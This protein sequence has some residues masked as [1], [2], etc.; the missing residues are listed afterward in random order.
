MGVI[1][2]PIMKKMLLQYKFDHKKF[3]L[4]MR[5]V[6]S[7][8]AIF[9]V[10]LLFHLLGWHGIQIGTLTAVFSLREDFDKSVSF[11]LSRVIGNS[12]GGI[13]ALIFL[14]I[15]QFFHESF[16]VTLFLI[17]IFSMLVIMINVAIS[18]KA[19]VIGSIAA[20]LIISTSIPVGDTTMYAIARIFETFCGVFIATLV[21]ADIDRLRKKLKK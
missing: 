12:I 18:N 21:N 3:K 7:G 14:I 13:L 4:G 5:T 2:N 15:H 6:K 11:G 17:P 9:I 20:F 10:I 19:G 1:V 16:F 8:L